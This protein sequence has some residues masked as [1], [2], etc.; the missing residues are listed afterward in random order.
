MAVTADCKNTSLSDSSTP[1]ICPLNPR[2]GRVGRGSV[3]TRTDRTVPGHG[4]FRGSHGSPKRP[5]PSGGR[6]WTGERFRGSAS[7]GRPW[8]PASY[9]TVRRF[10]TDPGGRVT[11]GTG[12]RQAGFHGNLSGARRARPQPRHRPR[13]RSADMDPPGPHRH[14]SWRGFEG[15]ITGPPAGAGWRRVN[16]RP[17]EKRDHGFPKLDSGLG[18]SVLDSSG[19]LRVDLPR[20]ESQLGELP[21]A[22]GEHLS[23]D[24]AHGIL[25]L[26]EPAGRAVP[27]DA[28]ERKSPAFP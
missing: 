26:V 24:A 23:S 20:D 2:S 14:G 11:G 10:G 15:G 6:E 16:R 19:D 25:E 28:H 22:G 3:Q 9:R 4:G 21:K 12:F 27:E 17:C 8:R 5:G 18:E 13:V 1:R 7:H